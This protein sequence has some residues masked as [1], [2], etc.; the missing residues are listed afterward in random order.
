MG[1]ATGPG[2][3]GPGLRGVGRFPSL[4]GDRDLDRGAGDASCPS[5]TTVGSL[6][7]KM[8]AA[9]PPNMAAT[10]LTNL[11]GPPVGAL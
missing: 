5:E 11:L 7:G 2:D 9:P 4:V 10:P 8:D 1:E 3:T 6:A